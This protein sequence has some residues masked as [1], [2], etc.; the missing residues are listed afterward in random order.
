MLEKEKSKG[1]YYLY[2]SVSLDG[3]G[4]ILLGIVLEVL[5]Q[6]GIY[7]ELLKPGLEWFV[8]ISLFCFGGAWALIKLL[9]HWIK[10]RK[11]DRLS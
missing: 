2:L 5:I 4:V 9:L 6:M 7:F 11:Y 10:I 8:F 1:R 3:L